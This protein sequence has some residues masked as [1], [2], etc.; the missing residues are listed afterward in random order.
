[1]REQI[2]FGELMG[3]RGVPRELRSREDD[4]VLERLRVSAAGEPLH[5]SQGKNPAVIKV[6]T[7]G[8]RDEGV[9]ARR[10][11]EKRWR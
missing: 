7:W 5:L 1:M 2:D 9:L 8:R 6:K 3:W 10:Q 11:S 4:K